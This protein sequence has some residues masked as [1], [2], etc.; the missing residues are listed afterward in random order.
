VTGALA[1]GERVWG[2][3]ITFFRAATAVAGAKRAASRRARCC[4]PMAPSPTWRRDGCAT[5]S[6]SRAAASASP[7]PRS[8]T[9]RSPARLAPRAQRRHGREPLHGARSERQ[10]R[11]RLRPRARRDAAGPAA[12]R[13]RRL[14]QGPASRADEPLLQR[15]AARGA[16]HARRS[17]V[18][19]PVAGRA[20]LDH[21]WSDAYLDPGAAAGTGSA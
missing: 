17:R 18:D 19:R 20:W 12:R 10:R 6:A 7:R 5:T 3:Q 16:R 21:E 13:R 14:A 8:A 4:S 15:A 9:P 1:A 2:F 11:L